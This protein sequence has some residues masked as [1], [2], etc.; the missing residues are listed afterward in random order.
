MSLTVADKDCA[1]GYLES[2]S[3]SL[4]DGMTLVSSNWGDASSDM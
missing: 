1:N 3:K 4:K 2:M